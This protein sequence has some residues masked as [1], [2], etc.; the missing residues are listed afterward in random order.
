MRLL[1]RLPNGDFELIS[2][3]DD[4]PP[5]Y[6]ILSHLWTD[7]Q[8]VTY[9]ELVARGGRDKTGYA[10][11]RFCG[12]RAAQDGLEY[13]WVDTCCINKSTSD[14]LST[15]I[16]SMFCYYQ[17]A[18]KCYVYLSDVQVPDEVTDAQAFRITWEDAFRRS[19]WFTRGWTLQ[20]LLAP[21]TV[22]FFSK[23][24]KRLGSKISLEQEIH[25]I[26]QIPIAA[27]RGQSLIEFGVEERM[28][29]AARRT[30]TFKEDEVYCLLGIFRVFLPLI[31]GEG[32]AYATLR[33]REEVQRR[34]EG[35]GIE[36]LQDLTGASLAEHSSISLYEDMRL[37]M[38]SFPAITI[39]KKR[40]IYWTRRRA[41]I[42]RTVPP[43]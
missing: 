14:E 8:E 39:P 9:G 36:S 27:L 16:N 34:Q 25:E 10:K 11:I 15:A 38:C 30:T 5:P 37:T 24:G 26:T 7:G 42:P 23:D 18:S 12:A 31:Y 40:T 28:S 17:R 3:N 6:A 41:P 43:P 20:E 21:P 2:F 35:Q 22:E 32:K 13:F 33:L 4:D 29:W 1:K 19:R